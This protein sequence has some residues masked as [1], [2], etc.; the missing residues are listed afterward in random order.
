MGAVTEAIAMFSVG[1]LLL[2]G[3]ISQPTKLTIIHAAARYDQAL[4]VI[5]E[6]LS[7]N[8]KL[9]TVD[10]ISTIVGANEIAAVLFS[11]LRSAKLR[12]W[13]SPE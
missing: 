13:R 5:I 8:C 12:H 10:G 7:V 2:K 9:F 4:T 11:R 1:R 6:L 3:M